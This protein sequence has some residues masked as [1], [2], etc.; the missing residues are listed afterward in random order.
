MIIARAPLRISFGG[1]GTDLAAY[2]ERYGGMV[3]STSINK[4]VYSVTT[5]N[6]DTHFQVISADYQSV[7]SLPSDSRATGSG[8]LQ[9][10]RAVYDYFGKAIPVNVFLASEVP[11]GTGLGSSGATCVNLCTVFGTLSGQSRTQAQVAELAYEIEVDHLHAS[12]GK[13]DQYAS[14]IGGLNCFHFDAD[15]VR[16]TPLQMRAS[17]IRTLEQ[18]LML[19]YTGCT[20]SAN[21]ILER[22]RDAT[23]RNEGAI[24]NQLHDIKNLAGLMKETLEADKLDDFAEL[25]HQ[26]WLTKRSLVTGI[27]NGFIDTCYA[28]ALKAGALGGK[29]AGA[30]GGGFLLLYCHEDAQQN[31]RTV[32]EA[33]GMREVHFAFDF[34]GARILMHTMQFGS[35]LDWRR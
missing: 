7:I 34:E 32:L 15:G 11:P 18:R 4:Y 13:Q 10:P 31:V 17:T 16:V 9:V 19:F 6:F 3:V 2:Y 23:A 21:Q 30:G 20:R 33:H 12:V 24:L 8:E 27:S 29:I 25:L 22:Q 1:G 28:D 26:S 14:A 35:P 5:K